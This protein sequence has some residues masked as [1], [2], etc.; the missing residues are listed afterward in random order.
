MLLAEDKSKNES[1][2]L[3]V[4]VGIL[5]VK[6]DNR[7]HTWSDSYLKLPFQSKS[8]QSPIGHFADEDFEI[9]TDFRA[10][11]LRPQILQELQKTSEIFSFIA[12]SKAMTDFPNKKQK[13]IKGKNK[14]WLS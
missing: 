14:I 1:Y 5:K 12:I 10:K 6:V 2:I 13:T 9:S 3:K 11:N 4:E 8:F 7:C